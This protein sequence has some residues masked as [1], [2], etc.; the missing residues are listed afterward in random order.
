MAHPPRTLSIGFCMP[1]LLA[2]LKKNIT[3]SR[4]ACKDD[5]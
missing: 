4:K 5:E 1:A 3:Q 2:D